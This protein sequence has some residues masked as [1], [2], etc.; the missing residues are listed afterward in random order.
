[1]RKSLFLC[2]RG[3]NCLFLRAC[4]RCLCRLSRS[5][6]GWLLCRFLCRG[7]LRRFLRA[8][9]CVCA[10]RICIACALRRLLRV[11]I[12]ICAI[13][14]ARV[15]CNYRRIIIVY[16][17]IEIQNL[18]GYCIDVIFVFKT[19]ALE[20][21]VI[22]HPAVLPLEFGVKEFSGILCNARVC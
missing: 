9:I 7:A 12:C 14:C 17:L 20:F 2:C 8:C 4:A 6:L 1:M 18:A 11:C 22:H 19:F 5:G 16:F 10:T 21:Y 13:A 15:A 3:S